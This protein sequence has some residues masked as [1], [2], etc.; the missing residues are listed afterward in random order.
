M[1]LADL[2][3]IRWRKAGISE[4]VIGAFYHLHG[5]PSDKVSAWVLNDDRKIG[6]WVLQLP[7]SNEEIA[8]HDVGMLLRQL[9]FS[10]ESV[11]ETQGRFI[12]RT[13]LRGVQGAIYAVVAVPIALVGGAVG[14]TIDMFRSLF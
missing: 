13:L 7:Y 5:A 9:G 12:G 14:Y 6:I 1:K 11:T 2:W 8:D 3:V 4:R 10:I